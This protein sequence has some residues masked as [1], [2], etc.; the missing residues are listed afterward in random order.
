MAKP[1]RGVA[2]ASEL[3]AQQFAEW[4]ASFKYDP[5]EWVLACYPWNDPSTRLKGYFGPE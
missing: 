3:D 1:E 2:F 5:Y 4:V